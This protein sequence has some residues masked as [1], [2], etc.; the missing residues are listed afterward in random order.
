MMDILPSANSSEMVE[1]L[2]AALAS[3]GILTPPPA[4]GPETGT[5]LFADP[6]GQ[7]WQCDDEPGHAAEYHDAGGE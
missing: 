2:T 6:H 3:L 7:W 1:A 5:A 4:P